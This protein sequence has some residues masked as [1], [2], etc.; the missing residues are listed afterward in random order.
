[1]P[2]ELQT[3]R[4]EG[5]HDFFTYVVKPQDTL[6]DLCM[7]TMGRYDNVVLT[8]VQKLNPQLRNPNHLEVGQEIHFPVNYSK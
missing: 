1:M 5:S 4:G 2:E 8:K 7:S 6:R 3:G